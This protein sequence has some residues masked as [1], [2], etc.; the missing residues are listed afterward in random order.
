M[1]RSVFL[2]LRLL[3]INSQTISL[4]YGPVADDGWANDQRSNRSVVLVGVVKVKRQGVVT[5]HVT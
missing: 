1:R 2:T 3:R 4:S 5:T